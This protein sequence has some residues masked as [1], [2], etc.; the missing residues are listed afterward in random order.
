MWK[1][2]RLITAAS[3]LGI[4]AAASFGGMA[5]AA[6][7]GG[8]LS[9]ATLTGGSLAI[10]GAAPGNFTGTL[11]GASQNLYSTLAGYTATDPTGSGSGWHLQ[12]QASQFATTAPVHSLPVASLYMAAPT[13]A[14]NVNTT[15]CTGVSAAPTVSITGEANALDNGAVAL[16]STAV[17]T[18]MGAYDFTPADFAGQTGSQLKLVVPVGTYAGSYTS[19]LTVSIISAP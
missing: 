13:V 4:T 19:T 18:G 3:L 17:N 12:I 1:T 6:T 5:H 14:C 9:T 2:A 15:P 8:N 16:A 11:T 7:N 10:T